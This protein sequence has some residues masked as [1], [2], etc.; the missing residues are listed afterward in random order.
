ME[1]A[2]EKSVMKISAYACLAAQK[3]KISLANGADASMGFYHII[4][5]SHEELLVLSLLAGWLHIPV[6]SR[7]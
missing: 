2:V 7:I 5:T 6:F 4:R 3:T 1:S